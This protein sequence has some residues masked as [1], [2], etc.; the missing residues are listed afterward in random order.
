MLILSIG[1]VSLLRAQDAGTAKLTGTIIDQHG[2][3]IINAAVEVK[4]ESSTL[5]RKVTSDSDGHFVAEGLTAGAYAV[6]VSAPGFSTRVRKGVQVSAT[7]AN[8][9]S[10]PLG[11]GSQLE[12]VTVTADGSSSIAS[13]LSPVKALLTERSATSVITS[14]F[15]QNFTSPVADYGELVQMVPGAFTVSS[16]GVGMGQSKT[17]FRGFPDGDYDIDY[18]GIPF[19]DTNSPTH[20]SW[21]F[22]PSQW[23]GGVNFDRSPG[24]AATIGPTPFGGSIHLLSKEMPTQLNIRG[25]AIYGSWNT[26]LYDG[27]LDTGNFGP[28]GRQNVIVDVHHMTSDGYQTYNDQTRNAGE[29]KYQ[30]RISDKTILTGYSGV[31]ILDSNTPNFNGPTRSQLTQY[32]DN[33]LLTNNSNSTYYSDQK[34]NFYHVPTDFE[35]VGLKSELG[36]GWLLDVKPYTYSYNNAQHYANAYGQDYSANGTIPALPFGYLTE[37]AAAAKANGVSTCSTEVAKKGVT[38]L[39]CGVDKLNSYRK[40]GDTAAI[41]QT[42]KLG[43]FRAGLWYEWAGTNRY[44][45]P[46]DPLNGWADQVLPNFHEQFWTNSYQPYAEYEFHVTHKLNITGG[47]KFADYA[48]SLKQYA[49]DGKTVGSL[50]G[51]PFVRNQTNYTSVLPSLDANYHILSNWT[52][53]GQFATGSVVPPSSVFDYNQTTADAKTGKTAIVESLPKPTHTT[54]FQ[55]GTVVKFR[56]VSF[57][58][59]Y[60]HTKFQNAYSSATDPVTGEQDNYLAP[61]SISQGIEAEANVYLGHGLSAYVNATKGQA[62][63]TGNLYVSDTG[64]TKNTVVPPGTPNTIAFSAPSGLWVSQ[65]PSDTEAVGLSYQDKSWNVGIFEKRIG[66][67]WMDNG[68]YHNQMAVDPFNMTNLFLGYTIHNHSHFDQTKFRLAINNLFDQHSVTGVTPFSSVAAPITSGVT[69]PFV[70]TTAV[71]QNDVM[72]LLP[73]R[74]VMMSVTFGFSPRRDRD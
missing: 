49:D 50:N 46:S 45:T 69:N 53:Y 6:E 36:H 19:Y 40:Y 60:Y 52:A 70:G 54:S 30:F 33:F 18:D 25:N 72:S 56:R 39:P 66:S 38:A 4:S 68:S 21:A 1:Q 16:D 2:S 15:I 28:G 20:H 12:E 71:S 3:V 62:T 26:Q 43:V 13:Q 44:Q 55:A 35:Y 41:S 48:L 74:C 37:N 10:I 9:I 64:T 8:N 58:A 29:L 7:G 24:S 31:V 17:Y 59:D 73:G 63:Y 47:V 5:V 23:I 57:D 34:Y 27:A 65:T 67:E 42:S 32:G 61:D 14:D 51:S 11:V 22:F